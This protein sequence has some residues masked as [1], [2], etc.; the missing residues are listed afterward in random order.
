[1]SYKILKTEKLPHSQLKIEAEIEA[2]EFMSFWPKAL[3]YLSEN[4]K[5]DGFRPGKVPENVLISK[6]GEMGVLEETAEMAVAEYYSKIII[7]EKISAIGRPQ[8]TLT[9]LAKDN[10]LNFTIV[11]AI[12]PEFELPEY[13]KIAKEVMAKEESVEV[14]EKEYDEFIQAIRK[15][16]A[17]HVHAEG[18]EHKDD[19]HVELPEVTDEFVRALGDFENIEDFNKKA[20]ENLQQEKIY[21]S[22]EKLRLETL[23]KLVEKTEIDLPEVLIESELNKLQSQFEENLAGMNI[24]M[25]EYF[26]RI[27]KTAEEVRAE[28]RPEAEKRAKIQLIINKI[29]LKE[30]LEP[31]AEDIKKETAHLL[32]Q[33]KDADPRRL[34]LYVETMLVNDKVFQFLEEQK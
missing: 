27:N 22:K 24:P 17:P 29:A 31:A 15:S 3:K 18:E 12:A 6:I 33:Y 34:E 23:D 21:R 16:R 8:I 7:G 19:E 1:M 28:W 11:T 32:A 20:R 4:A 14:T 2:K 10:P 5:L 25:D 13:K 9:K 30:K 26:K